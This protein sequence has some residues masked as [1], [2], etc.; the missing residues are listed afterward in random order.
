MTGD[1]NT[2]KILEISSEIFIFRKGT[3]NAIKHANT[4]VYVNDCLNIST[5][6][7][8]NHYNFNIFL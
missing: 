5:F 7:I 1:F 6:C 3:F 4:Q 8:I 2:Y